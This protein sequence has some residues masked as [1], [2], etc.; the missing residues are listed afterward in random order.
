M[1]SSTV[2]ARVGSG[3]GRGIAVRWPGE[4]ESF[5]FKRSC[6]EAEYNELGGWG[7]GLIAFKN[8]FRYFRI[9]FAQIALFSCSLPRDMLALDVD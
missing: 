1:E 8:V 9:I 5:E 6:W 7:S 2:G 3:V 4:K